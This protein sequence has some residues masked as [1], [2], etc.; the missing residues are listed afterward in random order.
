MPYGGQNGATVVFFIGDDFLELVDHETCTKLMQIAAHA[1]TLRVKRERRQKQLRN[2][3]QAAIAQADLHTLMQEDE[4]TGDEMNPEHLCS[5]G[6]SCLSQPA[7]APCRKNSWPTFVCWDPGVPQWQPRLS[8]PAGDA[9]R[10][11]SLRRQS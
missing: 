9:P 8:P 5:A 11:H 1:K 6:S 7:V 2:T 3:L 10:A 4:Q